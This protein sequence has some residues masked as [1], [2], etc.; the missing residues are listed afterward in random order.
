[1]IAMILVV[2]SKIDEVWCK[3]FN[4]DDITQ[5]FPALLWPARPLVT[6]TSTSSGSRVLLCIPCTLAT[7]GRFML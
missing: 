6:R 5:A 2:K 7:R 4:R 3:S 1:M